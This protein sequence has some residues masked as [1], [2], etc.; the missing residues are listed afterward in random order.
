MLNVVR[1]GQLPPGKGGLDQEE[2]QHDGAE[3]DDQPAVEQHRYRIRLKDLVVPAPDL[4]STTPQ[5]LG[6]ESPRASES[7]RYL[8]QREA[9]DV[10]AEA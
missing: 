10:L 8:P 7:S 5:V 2:G 6:L 3:S 1:T 9:I 4:V